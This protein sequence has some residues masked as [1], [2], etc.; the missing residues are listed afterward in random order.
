MEK[1]ANGTLIAETDVEFI[2][3]IRAIKDPVELLSEIV[4]NETFL[5]YDSYYR[6]LRGAL[7]DQAYKIVEANRKRG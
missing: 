4:E 1:L 6:D 2:K 7:L 3:R 5:G